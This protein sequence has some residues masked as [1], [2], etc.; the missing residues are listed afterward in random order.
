MKKISNGNQKDAGM[1][2]SNAEHLLLVHNLH[3]LGGNT[4]W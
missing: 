4:E 3:K 2:L 1:L